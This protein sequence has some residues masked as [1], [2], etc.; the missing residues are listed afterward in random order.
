MESE[1]TEN[2]LEGARINELGTGRRVYGNG[3]QPRDSIVDTKRDVP[4]PRK[5]DLKNPRLGL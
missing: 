1:K 5:N 3:L 2:P 4:N